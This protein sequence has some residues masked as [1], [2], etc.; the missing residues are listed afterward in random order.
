MGNINAVVDL[1]Q[2]GDV[3]VIAMDNPPVN[4]LG[5]VL[6]EGVMQA[7]ARLASTPEAKAVVLTGTARAFSGGADISEFGKPPRAPMLSDVVAMVE[8]CDRPVVA[9]ISGVALGGGLELALGCH[10]RV[11]APGARLGLPEVKLGL[12]PGAGGTQRLPR[13]MGPVAAM[14]A[15]VGGTHLSPEAAD[16]LVDAICATREEAVAFARGCI[17]KPLGAASATAKTNW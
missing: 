17:G 3:A 9:A 4:A 1:Q 13:V 6:R 7:F 11:A 5:I 14:K 15:I 10:Y 16:G 8:A 2:H 12:L